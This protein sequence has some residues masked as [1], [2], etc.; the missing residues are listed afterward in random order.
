[1][2]TGLVLSGG[3]FRGVAHI[4]AIKALEENQIYPSHISGSSAGAI[5]GAFYASGYNPEEILDFF[6]TIPIFHP[7]RYAFK[8]AGFI[9][10]DT[11]L[12]DFKKYFPIDNFEALEKKLFI[13]T[14]DLTHGNVKVF[15]RG[16]LIKPFL[17][18]AAFPGIF[19]PVIIDNCLYADG[20][21][22]D[23]FPID[24]LKGI[25]D[26]IIGVYVDPILKIE[27]GTI[28]HSY[29][30]LQRAIKINF[31]KDSSKKFE[32]CDLLIYPYK[33]NEFNLFDKNNIDEIYQIGYNV[34]QENIKKNNLFLR[35]N[36]KEERFI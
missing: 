36:Q 1:M 7:S 20:G 19:S 5:V 2:G 13:T 26:K 32:D 11:Y 21:I 27:T 24:P 17:A 12:S 15:D 29:E 28:K 23:N 35:L 30:V 34:A 3:G 6:K 31:F 4:G 14:V 10:T 16:E 22:L 25:C 9:D 33:L 18:S 8:K